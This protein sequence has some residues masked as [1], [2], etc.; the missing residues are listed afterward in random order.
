MAHPLAIGTDGYLGAERSTLAIATRG[1]LHSDVAQAAILYRHDTFA[2]GI[3]LPVDVLAA[4]GLSVILEGRAVEL[5]E[6]QRRANSFT[7]LRESTVAEVLRQERILA[8]TRSPDPIDV[9]RSS[10]TEGFGTA[11][12]QNLVVFPRA[13][14]N[15]VVLT[16]KS[17]EELG[18]LDSDYVEDYFGVDGFMTVRRLSDDFRDSIPMIPVPEET[19]GI[20]NDVFRGTFD[21]S[22]MPNGFYE[23][24]GRVRDIMGNYTIFGAVQNPIG[25]E[26][27]TTLTLQIVDGFAA[28]YVYNLPAVTVRPS[29]SVDTVGRETGAMLDARSSAPIDTTRR[30]VEIIVNE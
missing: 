8:L 5:P 29:V 2:A 27:V 11:G 3:R 15:N 7:I 21:I 14:F 9:M 18:I 24:E 4:R 23:L 22:S 1:Y 26:N 17:N 19:P 30:F 28:R 10:S 16:I 13:S 12:Y 25:G 6:A 20:N